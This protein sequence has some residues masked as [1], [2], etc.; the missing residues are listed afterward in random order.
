MS[1]RKH[2]RTHKCA[3]THMHVRARTYA[4]MAWVG[5]GALHCTGE[6]VYCDDMALSSATLQGALVLSSRAHAR[7]D[8]VTRVHVCA[9]AH[10]HVCAAWRWILVD[11]VAFVVDKVEITKALLVPGVERVVLAYAA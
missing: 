8:K 11:D 7:I 2:A 4:S 9:H 1:P 10:V 6:A 3:H 5:S